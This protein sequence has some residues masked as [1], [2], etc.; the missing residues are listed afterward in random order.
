M[1]IIVFIE[2]N[3]EIMKLSFFE[4]LDVIVFIQYNVSLFQ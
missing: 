4:T 1:D 3:N 2:Y